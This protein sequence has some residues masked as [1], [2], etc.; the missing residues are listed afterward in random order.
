MTR[1][2]IILLV[3]ERT[4]VK[5]SAWSGHHSE[6]A[7]DSSVGCSIAA[8]RKTIKRLVSKGDYQT[9]KE[10][11]KPRR[12]KRRCCYWKCDILW[13][14]VKV[15]FWF[16]F[17]CEDNSESSFT[18]RSNSIEFLCRHVRTVTVASSSVLRLRSIFYDLFVRVSRLFL[19]T[20]RSLRIRLHFCGLRKKTWIIRSF[21]IVI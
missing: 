3:W 11:E 15:F 18:N 9:A 21:I 20:A 5:K 2:T 10:P 12:R 4:S 6:R 16:R 13:H 7:T 19:K 17:A 8:A 14:F 1:T